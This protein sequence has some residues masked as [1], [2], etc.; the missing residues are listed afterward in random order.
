MVHQHHQ[1]LYTFR[2]LLHHR[3]RH[4]RYE[5][6]EKG[7]T[8]RR[9]SL[10][11]FEVITTLSLAIGILL[12]DIIKPGKIDKTGLPIQDAS[13]YTKN[14]AA[15]INWGEFFLTNLTLQVLVLAIVAGIIVSLSRRREKI[16]N[17]IDPITKGIFR[18]LK[19]VML[20]APL[21]AF[22]GMAFT[23]GKYGVRTLIPREN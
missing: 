3:T 22:G 4:Q 5:Q 21:G 11:Y 16:L 6:P 9:K 17:W 10:L 8:H 12:A 13:K 7:R 2:H 20:L 18:L 23:I 1:G 14:N 19:Y 15:H